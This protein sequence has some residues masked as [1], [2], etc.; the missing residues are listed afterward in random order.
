[1]PLAL[2][3]EVQDGPLRRKCKAWI[4]TSKDVSPILRRIGAAIKKDSAERFAA[5][6]PGWAP[7]KAST[8]LK[9]TGEAQQLREQQTTQKRA[10][11]KVLVK[12]RRDFRRAKKKF[13][14][15]AAQRR[16][17]IIKEFERYIAGGRADVSLADKFSA[18]KTLKRTMERLDRQLKRDSGRLL[19]KMSGANQAKLDGKSVVVR[20][21]ARN[22]KGVRFSAAHNE[23][24]VV[25]HGA[26]LDKREFL[27]ITPDLADTFPRIVQNFYLEKW[28]KA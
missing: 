24:A 26:K 14:E 16:Y 8:E 2:V 9:R 5:G 4:D 10:Q 19:G 21:M 17:E 18:S 13:S 6:G 12:L 25:G 20:N 22:K 1:M 27:S 23:G 28:N 15:D 3:I 11:S 7:R